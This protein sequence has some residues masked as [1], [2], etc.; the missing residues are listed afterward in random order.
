MY[1]KTQTDATKNSALGM[2]RTQ[3][4]SRSKG[5]SQLAHLA[6]LPARQRRGCAAPSA[7]AAWPWTPTLGSPL[8]ALSGPLV[9]GRQTP[10]SYPV[11][12]GPG[13]GLRQTPGSGQCSNA[14]CGV[15]RVSKSLS[16]SK[17][18]PRRQPLG[19]PLK[20]LNA[21]RLRGLQ[22]PQIPTPQ[23]LRH[24]LGPLHT[25]AH[26]HYNVLVHITVATAVV[27]TSSTGHTN[28]LKG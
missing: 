12:H 10:I 19:T 2:E 14:G 4:L 23:R 24:S 11:R 6:A 27:R 16:P 25:G 9:L 7:S 21:R 22:G 18:S 8:T 17:C 28:V 15:S 3:K 20:A 26:S 5:L 13:R 1:V